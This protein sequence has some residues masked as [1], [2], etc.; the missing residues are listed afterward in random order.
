MLKESGVT[1]HMS[2]ALQCILHPMLPRDKYIILMLAQRCQ[3]IVKAI[4]S[5]NHRRQDRGAKLI[6]LKHTLYPL[7]KLER[8]RSHHRRICS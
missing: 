1:G 8:R 4:G 5:N 3:H 6:T 7:N 2:Q